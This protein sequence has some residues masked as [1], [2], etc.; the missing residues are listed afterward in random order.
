MCKP[1]PI[2]SICRKKWRHS[3]N[4]RA[5][6]WNP[7]LRHQQSRVIAKTPNQLGAVTFRIPKS[8]DF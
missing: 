6:G 1:S 3:W 4:K 5:V 8:P 2:T 7:T